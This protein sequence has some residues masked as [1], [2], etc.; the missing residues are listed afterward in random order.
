LKRESDIE[1]FVRDCSIERV[2]AWARTRVGPIGDAQDDGAATIYLTSCGPM[3]ATPSI[4]NG[5][6]MSVWFNS[7]RT[8][9]ATDV[10]CARDVARELECTV[11]CDPGQH[12]PDVPPE[13]S[14]FLEIAAGQ[15][16]LVD[17]E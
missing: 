9:W 11:R 12:Y 16:R 10:D 14:T 17:W 4:E 6:F 5:P 13:S 1:I 3:I 2:R 15:E 8:P 7:T